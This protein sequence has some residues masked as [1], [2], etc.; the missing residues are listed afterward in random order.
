MSLF[1][2]FLSYVEQHLPK[3]A[4]PCDTAQTMSRRRGR[5]KNGRKVPNSRLRCEIKLLNARSISPPNCFAKAGSDLAIINNESFEHD[6]I[7]DNV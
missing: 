6:A 1:L 5:P 7:V 4:V 2:S 3:S